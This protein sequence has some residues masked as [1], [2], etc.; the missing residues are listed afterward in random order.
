MWGGV[1]ECGAV[2]GVWGRVREWRQS[3]GSVGWSQRWV[4]QSQGVWD[5]VRECEAESGKSGVEPEK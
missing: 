1:R 4:G 2:R 5:R 3:Q